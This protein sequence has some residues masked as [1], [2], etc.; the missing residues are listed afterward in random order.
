MTARVRRAILAAAFVSTVAAALGTAF[1]PYLVVHHP[2]A[3]LVLSADARNLVLV[4]PRIDLPVVIA[5]A[6]PRRAVGMFVTFAVA[7]IYGRAM[8]A[9]SARRLP[10]ISRF[11]Q[12]LESVYMRVRGPLLLLWPM[13]VTSA[14]AGVTKMR[15]PR[16]LPWMLAGQL[17]HAVVVFYL[18]DLL[19][20]WTDRL[21]AWLTAHLVES[22]AACVALVAIQQLVAFVRRRRAAA[23]PGEA[24]AEELPAQR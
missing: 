5:V 10:R 23:T 18:G 22:T 2:I 17:A 14:L 16:Y 9:W 20:A 21:V 4:A 13:Y 1:L 3:L 12:R 19:G 24:P 7:L 15:A 6:F 8:L 11:F